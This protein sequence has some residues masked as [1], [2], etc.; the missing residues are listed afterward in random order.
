M[1]IKNLLSFAR[2]WFKIPDLIRYRKCYRNYFS[3]LKFRLGFFEKDTLHRIF[4]RDGREMKAARSGDYW[5]L[6]G[7]AKGK[8]YIIKNNFIVINNHVRPK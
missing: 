7:L 6:D 2:Q 3:A 5:I 1:T 4:L 8:D